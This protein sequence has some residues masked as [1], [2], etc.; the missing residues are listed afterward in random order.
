MPSSNEYLKTNLQFSN[1]DIENRPNS[2]LHGRKPFLNPSTSDGAGEVPMTTIS[3][4]PKTTVLRPDD[5]LLLDFEFINLN[6]E[7]GDAKVSRLVPVSGKQAY[8]VVNFPPQNIAE[9][10]F[11]EANPMEDDPD[12]PK[13]SKPRYVPDEKKPT[14]PEKIE[15]LPVQSRMSS[16]SRLVFEVPEGIREIPYTIPGLLNWVGY[17]QRVAPTALPPGTGRGQACNPRS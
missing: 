8:I 7:T 13:P 11:F 2:R 10:A 3:P 15:S 12:F 16:P 5:L 1:L 17:T 14:K 4:A 6:L 9:E